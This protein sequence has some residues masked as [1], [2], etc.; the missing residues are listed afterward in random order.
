MTFG[1][2]SLLVLLSGLMAG[3]AAANEPPPALPVVLETFDDR[4]RVEI[5]GQLF[6]DYVFKGA[7]RPYC[8]PVLAPDGT[9]L[10]RDF[11]MKETPGEDTDHRH[12]RAL[13]FAHSDVNGVDFWNEGSSGTP[14]PKGKTMHDALLETTSGEVGELR[15]R[16]R[17]LAPD[18]TLIAIDETT[19]RPRK[20]R[21]T[22]T[23]IR[24]A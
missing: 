6:T 14:Y 18:G 16:N 13:M 10:T 3:I 9:S 4:V 21:N 15:V 24:R 1:F 20:S 2:A 23:P 19:I 11:P 12:H 5:G 7:T 17:W 8:Y 22:N